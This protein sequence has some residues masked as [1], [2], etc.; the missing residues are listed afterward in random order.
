MRRPRE[1]DPHRVAKVSGPT[2]IVGRICDGED[3]I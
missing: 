2:F 1:R 3:L